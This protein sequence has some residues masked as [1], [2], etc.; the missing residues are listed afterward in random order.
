[1]STSTGRRTNLVRGGVLALAGLCAT[2]GR[3]AADDAPAGAAPDAKL[4]ERIVEVVAELRVEA[5][6]IRG[7]AWKRDVPIWK[8]EHFE[9]GAVWIG[10]P[11]DPQGV[12][13]RTEVR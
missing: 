1:M 8:K 11:D 6:K 10:T 3:V 9:G 5:S 7:L 13:S 12:L 4:R 2:G